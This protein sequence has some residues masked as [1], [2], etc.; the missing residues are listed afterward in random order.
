MGNVVSAN[1]GAALNG[2]TV[3]NLPDDA[4]TTT[5]ATPEDTAQGDGFYALFAGSGSQPFEASYPAY[6]PLTKSTTVIPNAHGPPR[7]RARRRPAL[8]EP[9]AAVHVHEPRRNAEPDAEPGQHRHRRGGYVIQEVNVPPSSVAP[10]GPATFADP[11]DVQAA[12]RRVG[13]ARMNDPDRSGV[14]APAKAPTNVAGCWRRRAMSSAPSR[15]GFR[16]AWASRTTRTP[17]GSGSPTP[18]APDAFVFGDGFEHQYLP[19]GTPTGDTI[20]I[21]DT[22]GLLQAD[23][24]YNGRTGMLWQVNVGGDN[25]LF[26]MDPV[27]KVVTGKKIC[28]SWT[29][30]SQRAVAYDYATDT[31]YVGGTNEAAVY[32]IDGSG[33]VLDSKYV[34]LGMAGLAFNPSTRHLFAL[35]EFAAPFEVWVLDT[36]DHYNVLGGFVVT[37]GGVPVLQNDGVSLEADCNGHLW[38][39]TRFAQIVYEFESGET[40]WCVNDIPWLSETPSAGSVPTGGSLPVT[41][42]FD[43]AGLLPGLRQGSLIF[44]TNTPN[45]VAAGAGRL[46]ASLQ[47]RAAGQL[48]LELHLRRRGRRR[49][50]GLRSADADVHLLP[51]RGRDAPE[52]GGLHRARR[53]RRPDAAA[54]LPR[55][56]RR[57]AGGQLQRQ[58]HPGA[59]RG[60]HHGGLQRG[61]AALLSGRSGHAGADG[62]LRV[63]GP[64]RVRTAAAL[65]ASRHFRRRAVPGRVRGGLH[66]GYLRREDH[67]R[68]RGFELLPE[69][70][71]HERADGGV[72]GQGVPDSL[73]AMRTRAMKQEGTAMNPLSM[74]RLA[75][76]ILCA[77]ALGASS[78]LA[79][80][81]TVHVSG[82]VTDGSGHGWPLFARIEIHLGLDRAGRGLLR[83][84]D[85]SVRR[86]W[87]RTGRRLRPS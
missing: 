74:K 19:D 20:D 83:P 37:S 40:G 8:G 6:E 61:T 28:G 22:G 70:E 52:H 59:R 2:A 27:T 77:A 41:V 12:L 86:R 68:L 9:P 81:P 17:T 7:L 50:A 1:G 13:F 84:G 5:F 49:H 85:R 75:A 23:G 51:E 63:E 25:C 87:W 36:A 65:H 64:A 32:H 44:T 79:G 4:S 30:N 57:R 14:P 29:A 35:T 34:G 26:E 58:L 48:R 73:P 43:P 82:T 62:G 80:S 72:P 56:V 55:R 78:A 3:L 18:T 45:P 67:G 39:N 16:R 53:P 69:C 54:R 42:T 31:Y 38:A 66:R 21:H 47:R 76:W 46:H 11:A 24:T 10:A 33:N 71:H 15:P 60:R